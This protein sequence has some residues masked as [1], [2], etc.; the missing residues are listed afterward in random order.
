MLVK[1]A[2]VGQFARRNQ[3]ATGVHADV[4]GHA[5]KLARQ[6]QQGAHVFLFGFAFRQ[7]GFGLGGINQFVV[8]FVARRRQLQG[9]GHTGLVRN[10]LADAIT[11]GVTHIQHT[12]H[13]ANRCTRGH[14][15]KGGNLTDCVLA[16]LFFHVVDDTVAVGLAKIDIKVW[17]RHPFWVQE[18]LKK[19]VVL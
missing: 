9:H 19:Q 6:F 7:N 14:G 2:E 10:Q 17:H 1:R 12:T 16:V 15:T 4:T 11:K 13:I 3:H 8:F 5:F 18:T